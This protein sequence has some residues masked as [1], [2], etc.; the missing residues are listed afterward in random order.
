MDVIDRTAPQHPTGST[1]NSTDCSNTTGEYAAL[2][3]D[4][5][6]KTE[7]LYM[8][9]FHFV[10]RQREKETAQE[11]KPGYYAVPPPLDDDWL[12]KWWDANDDDDDDDNGGVGGK[13]RVD[14]YRFL[15][16]GP[17]GSRTPLHHD[18]LCSYSWSANLAGSKRWRLFHSRH[19]PRLLHRRADRCVCAAWDVCDGGMP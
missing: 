10:L 4:G 5:V 1:H 6:A 13:G 2:W 19:T 14:D 16:L 18:V 3:R 7:G 9:D 12:N 11:G 15:Y 8:K 17:A